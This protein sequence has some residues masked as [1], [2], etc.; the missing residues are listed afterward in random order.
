M[1][2]GEFSVKCI[3]CSNFSEGQSRCPRSTFAT[4]DVPLSQLFSS[5]HNN[6]ASVILQDHPFTLPSSATLYS[7][8]PDCGPEENQLGILKTRRQK[9]STEHHHEWMTVVLLEP[10]DRSQD[11]QRNSQFKWREKSSVGEK[12]CVSSDT[13]DHEGKRG[14]EHLGKRK[15]A[16]EAEVMALAQGWILQGHS[17]SRPQSRGRL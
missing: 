7:P 2:H 15:R 13:G 5:H 9:L 1:G 14:G 12:A 17:P 10:G 6:T 8:K 4:D 3:I 16:R 11:F